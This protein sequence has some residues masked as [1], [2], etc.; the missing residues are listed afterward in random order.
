MAHTPTPWL[1]E[2]RII[3]AL[4][5]SGHFEGK[6]ADYHETLVNRFMASVQGQGA[7]GATEDE[8]EANAEFIVRAVNAYGK[9]VEALTLAENK[10]EAY[11]SSLGEPEPGWAVD[12]R[13]KAKDALAKAEGKEA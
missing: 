3:Y 8:L 11:A 13:R 7:T 5:A 12:A 4:Q 6:G 1:R 9:L 2:G 10:L